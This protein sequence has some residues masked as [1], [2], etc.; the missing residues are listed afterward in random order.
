[1][2]S[3]TKA[4][5]L[6]IILVIS[7][8]FD[9][10]VAKFGMYDLTPTSL[11]FVRIAAGTVIV[12]IIKVIR[13]DWSL[14]DKR[15][16]PV[17][18]ACAIFGQILYFECEYNAMT[19]LPVSLL[20]IVLGFVPAFSVIIERV[21]FKRRANR[22]I[23][24]GILFCIIGIAFVIGADFSIILEGRLVGYLIA[25][26]AIICW[27]VYNFLTASLEK[28]DPISLAFWQLLCASVL[29]SPIA[30]HNM[31][32]PTQWSGSLWLI[33]LYMGVISSAYGYMVI[34]YALKVIGPTPSAVYSDFMPVT[35]AICGA[36]FL[37]ESLSHLQIIGGIIV[38]AAGFVVIREKG[39]LDEQRQGL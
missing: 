19:Y 22:K 25:F 29:I 5:I 17:L 10:V 35:A 16:I 27:N 26:G 2:N 11:L 30:I 7:W 8:G 4:H 14:I 18:I 9:Y 37:H 38:I 34:V 3:K 13:R 28:Y 31:I 33:I 6:M 24:F 1:M 20:T 21:F 36:V 39:K 12:G 15:D 23:V 32:P